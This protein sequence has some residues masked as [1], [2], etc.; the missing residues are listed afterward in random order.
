VARPARVP[1]AQR[2]RPTAP[3]EEERGSRGRVLAAVATVALL[4][5]AVV[6]GVLL[7]RGG[8]DTGDRG[9]VPSPPVDTSLPD[10]QDPGSLAAPSNVRGKVVGDR[11]VFRWKV[12]PG[13][14]GY[15]V[16]GPDGTP[17]RTT[18]AQVGIPL[19]GASSMCVQVRSVGDGT[20]S[21]GSTQG[22]TG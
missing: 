8:D 19:H 17:H 16:T 11:A 15:L 3:V 18:T 5:A 20:G 9:Q 21:Q 22:C 4:V 14:S 1:D 10:V 6:V 12:V 2:A 7:S 13:A